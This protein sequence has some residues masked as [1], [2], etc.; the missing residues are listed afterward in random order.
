MFLGGED[1]PSYWQ[2][3][4]GEG[5]GRVSRRISRS[6]EEGHH[7]ING[8]CYHLYVKKKIVSVF[9]LKSA[10]HYNKLTELKDYFS[11][12]LFRSELMREWL[13]STRNIPLAFLA[14][15]RGS[16]SPSAG[17]KPSL[18]LWAI[19]TS[20]LRFLLIN[21]SDQLIWCHLNITTNA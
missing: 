6:A 2:A 1:P 19:P 17:L 4:N 9:I 15:Q 20:S 5:Q 18:S 8:M 13:D 10:I 14:T 21:W 16:M 7:H 12:F 11:L 3:W